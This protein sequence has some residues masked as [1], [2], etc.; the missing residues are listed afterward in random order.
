MCLLKKNPAPCLAHVSHSLLKDCLS[1]SFLFGGGGCGS[2][3]V[4]GISTDFLCVDQVCFL[5]PLCCVATLLL[6]L[7]HLS[8]KALAF[9]GKFIHF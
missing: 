1:F 6:L 5:T 3:S 4:L 8:Q 7:L 9:G 2:A